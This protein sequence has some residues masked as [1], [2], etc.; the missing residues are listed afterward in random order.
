MRNKYRADKT[1][2][3]MV[4][5]RIR[6]IAAIEH[7]GVTIDASVGYRQQWPDRLRGGRVF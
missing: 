2:V 5:W 1:V 7:S 6:R 3:C 4:T